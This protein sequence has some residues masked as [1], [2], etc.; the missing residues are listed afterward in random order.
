MLRRTRWPRCCSCWS[1]PLP[2]PPPPRIARRPA[3]SPSK[4]V[5]CRAS[6]ATCRQR[7][8]LPDYPRPQLVRSAWL[9]LNGLW[10]Y[11]IR[12]KD[13]ATPGA[14][15]DGSILVPVRARVVALRRRA[16][17]RPRT[18][19]SGTA[20]PSESR[21]PGPASASGCA[22][23]RWTGTRRC[24]STARRSARTPAATIP[25]RSTS[26]TRLEPPAI[27]S[28]SSRVWDPTDARPPAARQTGAEAAQHLVH[29]DH[30]HLADRV[31][32]AAARAGHRPP[33]ARRPTPTRAR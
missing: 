3:G 24:S 22:S 31:A 25:S 12:P 28:S 11:A 26:P 10:Q 19:G 29:A 8:R 18:S 13:A 21:R 7:A 2:R 9:N 20:A 23:T 30:R 14:A 15:F 4:A 33:E 16:N 17:G 5:C 6:R 1:W 27:R 32:R